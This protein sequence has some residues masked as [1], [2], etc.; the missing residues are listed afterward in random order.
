LYAEIARQTVEMVL[1]PLGA[2]V[3]L[4]GVLLV[5]RPW[6][7]IERALLAWGAGVLVQCLVFAT[8][9][10][11]ERARGTEY[12][13]LALVPVAAWLIAR[14]F[15]AVVQRLASA[16]AALRASVV[17]V[18]LVALAAGSFVITRRA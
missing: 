4:A 14:G 18:L 13:Q 12:Y 17:A 3:A 16:S 5:R 11:D 2:A 6:T 8:R 1:T 10:F 7:L 9:M 15:G